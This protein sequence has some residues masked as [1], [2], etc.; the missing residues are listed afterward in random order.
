MENTDT[1]TTQWPNKATEATFNSLVK[2]DEWTGRMAEEKLDTVDKL[3]RAIEQDCFGY[4][5]ANQQDENMIICDLAGALLQEC[6]FDSIAQYALDNW[7]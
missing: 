3:A 6:D 4:I 1:L 5:D 7:Q 2:E